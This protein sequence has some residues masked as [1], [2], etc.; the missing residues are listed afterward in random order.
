MLIVLVISLLAACAQPTAE[1]TAPLA[2]KA[3]ETKPVEETEAP[4]E[5]TEPV[6]EATEPVV[7]E[8]EV[9]VELTPAEQWAKDN[10]FGPYLSE[11][12][13]WAAIE[14][15]AKKEGKIVVYSNSS[16][17]ANLQEVWEAKY[18]DI[19]FEAYDLGTDGLVTKLRE[20]QLAGIY[21]ADIAMAS[22]P[23][24]GFEFPDLQYVWKYIPPEY[25]AVI[26]DGSKD[27]IVTHSLEVYGWTYNSQLNEACPITNW[28]E[29]ASE[30]WKGKV[31][32]NKD[33]VSSG[34]DMAML[35]FMASHADEFA[36]AYQELYGADWTTDPAYD[37]S[38]LDAG[39]LWLKKMAQN[40][41]IAGGDEAW[42]VM[43]AP[44]L[45]ENI[46][47]LFWYSK[48]REVKKGNAFFE[49]CVSLKPVI[50]VEKHNY[51]AVVNQA[52]H[53]N[54]AKL[55]FRFAMDTE[56]FGPW[57][58][59]G[60]RSPRTDLPPVDDY[61]PFLALPTWSLDEMFV[62]KETETYKDFYLLQLLGQ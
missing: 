10:G 54:A 25:E 15:A 13:D 45:Q 18:P 51:L 33:P 14:E 39:Y 16:R 5:E 1:P 20:E 26:P 3:P 52:P 2:T 32:I 57:N 24:M 31:A 11:T 59:V 37:P 41:M 28:W 21:N 55:Y 61:V 9:V 56:G 47:G 19:V 8:T 62:Y 34:S 40:Q 23:Y 27:P 42:Q 12:E 44:D 30:A 43:G 17:I 49:P 50:G 22:G 46:L 38:C 53:P 58:Q 7:E 4:V 6:E 29:P 48:Y 36:A 35:A 60:Q